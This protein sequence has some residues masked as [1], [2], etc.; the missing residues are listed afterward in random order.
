MKQIDPYII[1]QE[2]S[3]ERLAGSN[4]EK[5]GAEV[6]ISNLKQLG[7][8][9]KRESF[10][11]NSFDTGKGKLTID[12]KQ[13]EVVP[14]GLNKD[15]RVEGEFLFLENPEI[16]KQ[17]KGR[18]RGKIVA[19]YGFSRQLLESIQDQELAA[20]ISISRP[21][22][23]ASSSSHRQKT[24]KDGYTNSATMSYEDGI[25]AARLS[26]R[27]GVLKITQDVSE[28][29]ATNLIVDIEGTD[30]DDNLTYLVAHYDSVARSPGAS[31]NGGG[32]VSLIKIAE[33]F[34]NNRPK[35]NLRLI[36]FSG[37]ELGLLGSQ[38][39]VASHEE[40][41][42]KKGSLVLNIDV[43]GDRSEE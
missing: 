13:F 24:F 7:L 31:D 32:T 26:G 10:G 34:I 39:Y 6:I 41:V 23:K 19:A 38:H 29:K 12:D 28:K 42:I 4:N 21:E 3:F 43:S 17:N 37:E 16:L 1:L 14:F 33:Y 9:V 2:L 30:P 15:C 36:F 27:I 20:Y 18:Y 35:R 5:R 11:L 22:R 25:K 8:K 40:E